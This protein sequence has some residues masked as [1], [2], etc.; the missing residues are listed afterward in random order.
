MF[1]FIS[2]EENALLLKILFCVCEVF[3]SPL[4]ISRGSTYKGSL[5]LFKYS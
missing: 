3:L 4:G 2:S 5:T 1:I